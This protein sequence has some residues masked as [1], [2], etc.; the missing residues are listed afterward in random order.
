MSNTLPKEI[1][2]LVHHIELNKAGWWPK[3]IQ[4]FILSAIWLEGKE[5]SIQEI[6]NTL[7][8]LISKVIDSDSVALQV[9]LL[10][11]S[12]ILIPIGDKFKISERNIG[13]FND[14]LKKM[15]NTE[16]KVKE[17]FISI[18]KSCCAE[19]E[20]EETWKQF[21]SFLLSVIKEMGAKV[22]EALTET[23]Y[24]QLTKNRFSNFLSTF[25]P[26][27]QIKLNAAI[28]AFLDPKE[29]NVR[30]YILGFLSTYFFVEASGLNQGD[31]DAIDKIAGSKIDINVFLDTNF[32][33]SI[34]ALH[35]NPSNEAALSLSQLIESLN[36]RANAKL[37]VLPPTVDETKRVLIAVMQNARNL[38]IT[39]NVAQAVLDANLHISGLIKKY[40]EESHKTRRPL[41]VRDYFQPYI[42]NLIVILKTKKVELFNQNLDSYATK[43]AVVDDLLAQ[44]EY[45][46]KKW[47]IKAKDYE[48]LE[49][50]MILWHFTRDKRGAHIDD[51]WNAKYWIATVDF[52]FL[53]FDAFKNR[54][55]GNIPICIHPIT[56]IQLLQFWIP[57]TTQL[58]E[59]MI[60]ILRLPFLNQEFNPEAE[61]TTI[62]ILE[63]LN[64]FEN[65]GEL[66][67]ETI[68]KILLNDLLRQKMHATGGIEEQ[69]ALVREALIEENN[70][71]KRKLQEIH[72]NSAQIET[73]SKDTKKEMDSL[74]SKIKE[75]EFSLKGAHE[76]LATKKEEQQ[77]LEDKVEALERERKARTENGIILK[78]QTV[79]L[80]IVLISFLITIWIGDFLSKTFLGNINL[81]KKEILF[82]SFL[83][84]LWLACTDYVGNVIM[85]IKV[86]R[87]FIKFHIIKGWLFSILGTIFLGLLGKIVFEIYKNELNVFLMSV[88]GKNV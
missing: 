53:G 28:I 15:E 49:H 7:K 44:L 27:I 2:S 88:F 62:R 22:Y 45:E 1:V 33:F 8:K 23:A 70:E 20:P 40:I 79:F 3:A 47:G 6:L 4:K 85:S 32:L 19:L 73:I 65:V 55:S 56:L 50:D 31:L 86:S 74:E 35:E 10:S 51:P 61:K 21:D 63:I 9:D 76:I 57:R 37:Y 42:D 52:R 16:G 80:A 84:L 38:R 64:R 71:L 43:Q 60:S 87:F 46:K 26:E 39:P 48:K 24:S 78:R 29:I 5:L 54:A 59:T 11:K 41:S 83:V 36:K 18:L 17:R 68:T 13:E 77:R 66:A 72:A 82:D 69:I 34:L 81:L 58:E 12:G 67:P 25:S 14:Q 75:L 30:S